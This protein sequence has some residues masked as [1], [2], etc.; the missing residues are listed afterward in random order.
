MCKQDRRSGIVHGFI[1]ITIGREYASAGQGGIMIKFKI[2]KQ[3]LV[4]VFQM[5]KS[6]ASEKNSVKSIDVKVENNKLTATLSN[7]DDSLEIWREC[8]G[9][10]TGDF[11]MDSSQ[12]PLLT[13]FPGEE[14]EII[15][16]ENMVYIHS[17][18]KATKFSLTSV[19]TSKNTYNEEGLVSILEIAESRIK[20]LFDSLSS[21]LAPLDTRVMLNSFYV[22]NKNHKILA[23]NGYV[24]ASRNVNISE[25]GFPFYLS[26]V[27]Y[28]RLKKCLTSDNF[29]RIETNESM[30]RF[31]SRGICYRIKRDKTPYLKYGDML[32]MSARNRCKLDRDV[33][34]P[35]LTY[36]TKYRKDNSTPVHIAN[37][38]EALSLY[39]VDG[40][41]Q[42]LDA[43]VMTEH[44]FSDN[45]IVSVDPA[46][47]EMICKTMPD[48]W[49]DV[50][51][52]GVLKPIVVRG[53]LHEFILLPVQSKFKEEELR[54]M[55]C[56]FLKSQIPET[57]AS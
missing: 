9:E 34:L 18:G 26:K 45:L 7:P 19:T 10:C 38:G 24:I 43:L 25:L 40:E 21:Y 23:T 55:M 8:I 32:K 30:V 14:L 33:L 13:E 22:D 49:I 47:L 31:S 1:V 56:E 5:I 51:F 20:G 29:L 37:V 28:A 17:V 53:I 36:C 16:R 54:S 42:S 12:I 48:G 27:Q 35:I 2:D 52:G 44:D 11:S 57:N 41:F 39:M 46:L 50:S 3:D 15:V 6:A 4:S